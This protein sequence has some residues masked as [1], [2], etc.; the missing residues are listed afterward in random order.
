MT[1]L[2]CLH[3][4]V[5]RAQFYKDTI[6]CLDCGERWHNRPSYEFERKKGARIGKAKDK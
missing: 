3:A 4:N 2:T 6:I 5:V 1:V